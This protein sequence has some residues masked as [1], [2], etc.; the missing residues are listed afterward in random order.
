MTVADN[1]LE[2]ARAV[3]GRGACLNLGDA[4]E[5]SGIELSKG[6]ELLLQDAALRGAMAQAGMR[7]VDGQ[8]CYRIA[9]ALM[10]PGVKVR[11]ANVRDAELVFPWRNSDP[12]RRSSADPRPLMLEAHIEWFRRT[13]A[14]PH[15]ILL[16]AE[17]R[18]GPVG[19]LRYDLAGEVATVS[20]Y[21]DPAKH[22]RGMGS[23]VLH[24]AETWMRAGWPQVG[25]LRAEVLA[26]NAASHRLFRG[27]GYIQHGSQYEKILQ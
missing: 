9:D 22:G 21:L 25:R 13:L 17:D 11:L 27:T 1:Q 12:V 8:G 19:V 18:Q 6:L 4:A 20:I 14:D 26:D 16:I 2:S 5:I 23:A 24:V 7:L 3:A 15:R 10:F